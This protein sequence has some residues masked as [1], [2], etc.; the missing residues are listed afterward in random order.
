L[1]LT[2]VVP[3]GAGGTCTLLV[4]SK[5]ASGAQNKECKKQNIFHAQSRIE[6]N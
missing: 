5:A 6:L 2:R 1:T 3:C 4:L